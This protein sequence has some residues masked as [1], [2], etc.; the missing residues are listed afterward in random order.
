MNKFWRWL[1]QEDL[2]N[3]IKKKSEYQSDKIWKYMKEAEELKNK[4]DEKLKLEQ[5][6]DS[7]PDH[8][9]IESTKQLRKGFICGR[10]AFVTP[11]DSLIR[12]LVKDLIHS[13]FSFDDRV[14]MIME[15][16]KDEIKYKS[17]EK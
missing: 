1:R 3:E 10:E 7:V 4:L 13:D 2:I 5:I 15:M 6:W 16:V 17:D 9:Q 12:S 14:M 11:G 8:N